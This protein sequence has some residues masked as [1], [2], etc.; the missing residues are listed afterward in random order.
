MTIKQLK[1]SINLS[2]AALACVAL[3]V[4]AWGV[5]APVRVVV[6]ATPGASASSPRASSALSDEQRGPTLDQLRTIAAVNLRQPLRDPP[7][8][9][10]E[11]PTMQAK[12]VGT[13]NDQAHP[14]QS[15]AIFRLPDNSEHLL[16]AGQ[17]ISDPAGLIVLKR[18][19]DQ[20][21]WIEL[22]GQPQELQANSP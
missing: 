19:G 1:R 20:V 3:A 17:Q 14:D 6:P 9:I 16:K 21:V 12:F 22:D 7:P 10:I 2:A 5:L 18:V 15:L 4:L 13:I 8:Q 11:K